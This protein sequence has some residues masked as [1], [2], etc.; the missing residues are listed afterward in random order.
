MAHPI[1]ITDDSFNAEVIQSDTPVL[2]IG[3]QVDRR[4]SVKSMGR[5]PGPSSAP[6][7]TAVAETPFLNRL[8]EMDPDIQHWSLKSVATKTDTVRKRRERTFG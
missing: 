1:D 3:D 4:R 5:G 6:I 7:N 2:V 8:C